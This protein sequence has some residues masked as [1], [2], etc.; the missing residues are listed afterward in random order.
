M[1]CSQV[2]SILSQ[3]TAKTDNIAIPRADFD[4]LV[5]GGYL[6]VMQETDY[7]NLVSEISNF[8]RLNTAQQNEITKMAADNSTLNHDLKETH[9]IKWHFE[10]KEKKEMVTNRVN[11]EK[12][13][14]TT[15]ES[16]I[17]ARSVLINQLIQK[18]SLLDKIAKCTIAD[19]SV[20]CYVTVTA[21]GMTVLSDLNV[22]NYRVSDTDFSDFITESNATLTELKGIA[23]RAAG[24]AAELKKTFPDA[25][26]S[27]S[28]DDDDYD[29]QDHAMPL[30][31]VWGVAISLAK[32]QG[33]PTAISAMFFNNVTA[34]KE[35]NSDVFNTLL[36]A[37]VMTSLSLNANSQNVTQTIT[38]LITNLKSIISQISSIGVSAEKQVGIGAM[39]L[40]E[41][42]YDGTYPISRFSAFTK[43]STSFESAAILA[44]LN[45]PVDQTTTRFQEFQTMFQQWDSGVSYDTELA[46]AYLA[47]SG[48][49][50]DDIKVKLQIILQGLKTYLAYP[51]TPGAILASIPVFE[52]YETLDLMEKAC[53]FLT[54]YANTLE[55]SEAVSL[56]VRMIHGIK[57]ERVKEI[58]PA[59]PISSTPVQFTYTPSYYF[60]YWP[61]FFAHT[62]SHNT[63]SSAGGFHP[64]HAHGVGG[65]SG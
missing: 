44:G 49:Q 50:P 38:D 60:V 39:L 30:S 56:A 11:E 12:G 36:A 17:A 13:E 53:T 8:D 28:T 5:S 16:D 19:T 41:R 45:A 58:N 4:F 61:L 51:A 54:S 63:F 29:D 2:R 22:R 35:F 21:A 25:R 7:Q 10:S 65:F 9:S 62:Y 46:S 27:Y 47:A 1:K 42:M 57:N 18:K 24:Y 37:E 34:L 6:S 55:R 59:A 40:A 3:I 14:V 33:D 48:F 15:E 31:Q 43:V 64:G 23:E 20:P 52:A 26:N 32:L